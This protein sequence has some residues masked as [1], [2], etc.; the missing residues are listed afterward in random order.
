MIVSKTPSSGD[1]DDGQEY[2]VCT[3]IIPL[4]T[5]CLFRHNTFT[6]TMAWITY[7]TERWNSHLPMDPTPLI[8]EYRS[9]WHPYGTIPTKLYA[10]MS[11]DTVHS[12][13]AEKAP[14]F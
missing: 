2:A 13:K 1:E 10:V 11:T 7:G 5:V 4:K 8:P 14:K 9:R 6:L 12:Q 3:T